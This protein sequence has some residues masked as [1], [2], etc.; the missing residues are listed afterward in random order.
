[1]ALILVACSPE[2][3]ID[4]LQAPETLPLAVKQKSVEAALK[5]YSTALYQEDIDRL[6]SFL[7]L[8]DPSLPMALSTSETR[9]ESTVGTA[10]SAANFVET[11]RDTFSRQ[12]VIAHQFLNP[13]IDV[14]NDVPQASFIEVLTQLNVLDD[15]PVQRTQIWNTSL[16]FRQTERDGLIF[17]EIETI[18]RQGSLAEI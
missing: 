14:T 10:V 13:A 12:T 2:G 6:Q 8:P 7:L 18:L 17:F 3:E 1:M 5:G 9:R 11:I 15:T 16:T 4:R